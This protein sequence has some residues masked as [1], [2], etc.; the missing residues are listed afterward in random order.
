MKKFILSLFVSISTFAAFAQVPGAP[1]GAKMPDMNRGHVF[2]KVVDDQGKPVEFAS[3]VLLKTVMDP[4]TKKPKDILVKAQAAELNGDFNFKEI[5]INVKLKIKISFVGFTTYEGAIAF[6]MPP[7]GGMKPGQAP[8]PEMMAKLMAAFEKDLGNI[9]LAP[10]SKELDAVVVTG[11]KS[12]VEMDID[13][14]SFNVSQNLVTTGGTAIDVMRNIP[15]VQVDIDGNVKVR[16]ANPTLFIDGRPTSLTMDQIPADIIDKVEVITNPSAKYDASGSV[17]GIINIVLKKN[18]KNG[19]N[20]MVNV[21]ANRRGGT[22]VMGNFSFQ[23]NKWNLTGTLLNNM[24][25]NESNGYSD[26]QS[27]IGGIASSIYQ[28]SDNKTKGFMLFPR[29]SADY[30]LS[31]RSTLTLGAFF[32]GGGQFKPKENLQITSTIN[33]IKSFSNRYTESLREF[34]PQGFQLGFKHTFPKAG[35][36]LTMDMNF[37]GGTNKNESL[38]TTNYLNNNAITGTQIQKNAGEGNN[39]FIT[40]QTDYVKPIK[41]EGSIEMGLRAQINELANKNDNTLKAVGSD[42]YKTIPSASINYSSLNNVYAA[43]LSVSGKTTAFSYKVGLRGESSNYTGELLTTN[44][45]FSNKYPLSLFP[46]IFLKK[47]LSKTDQLQLSITRRVNRPNFF[48]LIPFVDYSDSLNITRGNADLVPEFTTSGELSY[49]KTKGSATFLFSGYYKYTDNLITRYYSQE[50]N[51]ISGRLDLINTFINANSSIN[52]GAELTYTNKFQ[53]W[54]DFTANVNVYNSKINVSNIESSGAVADGMWTAFGKVNNNFMLPKKW[55]IQLSADYQGKTNMPVSQGQGQMGPPGMQAQSS[56]QGYV[57][58]YYGIDIAI[59]K[60][61]LKNDMASLTLAF[62]DI[63]KT[64][65][66]TRVSF[67]EGFTQTSYR[68]S[69]PQQVRLTL[70]VRFGKFDMSQMKKNNSSNVDMQQMQ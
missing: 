3:V 65:G 2:G 63:G 44:Q 11:T 24:E 12:L 32:G 9:K 30:A 55:V 51:P 46:S 64:R 41:N 40:I 33:G 54:W 53:N 7:M 58:P 10:D 18:K 28:E 56:S 37:F 20:G 21:G 49:S 60:T 39:K 26:R 61:F 15:S 50:I 66:N 36:E 38:I 34:K 13:K 68:I 5:P 45:K 14:K 8:D 6:A 29:F 67:G 19:Y 42:V 31:N 27:T 35:E 16:N 43:Y 1:A 47:D 22:N 52:Y 4:A 23:Q 17:A 69:N 48:Q 57:Q 62:N 70:S 59:K 25:R